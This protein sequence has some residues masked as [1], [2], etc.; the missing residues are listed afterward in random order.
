MSKIIDKLW[1][2]PFILAL[3]VIL[4]FAAVLASLFPLPYFLG[5]SIPYLVVGNLAL[6][7]YVAVKHRAQLLKVA[8]VSVV[9]LGLAYLW[10]IQTA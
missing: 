3:A 4:S 8:L 10:A 7:T 6:I 9:S 2:L 1:L 5:F